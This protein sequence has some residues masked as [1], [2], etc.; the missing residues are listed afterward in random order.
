MKEISDSYKR[1]I[2]EEKIMEIPSSISN[3]QSIDSWR[4]YR[5]LHEL[6][7]IINFMPDAKWMTIGDG[8]YASDA[9]YLEK[10]GVDVLAT[11][12]TDEKLAISKKMG[13]IKN[14]RAENAEKISLDDNSIDFV[15][16]KEAYHHLPRPPIGLYEMLRVSKEALIII[17]PIEGTR[18][19]NKIKQL[20]K[21]LIRREKDIQF[22]VSG[23]FLYK[24]DL[25]E[26]DK[27]LHAMGKKR[28]SYKGINDFYHSG[29]GKFEINSINLQSFITKLA[30][31]VQNILSKLRLYT[32]GLASIVIFKD[33]PSPKLIKA[34]SSAGY[35]NIKLKKNP[36]T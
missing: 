28:Y 29:F 21:L 2:A 23:N 10:K 33:E 14:Y 27:L 15:L 30:I 8:R 25:K 18:I 19:F 4:H 5:I 13:Y 11:S 34:L 35:T 12:L 31:N 32:P 9:A 24:V 22:E 3:P 7:Q 16:C 36:Y 26:L 17:E 20:I 1:Q 6:S